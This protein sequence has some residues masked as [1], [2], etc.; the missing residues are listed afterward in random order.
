MATT[1]EC[2]D[3]QH[4]MWLLLMEEGVEEGVEEDVK[5]LVAF[6]VLLLDDPLLRQLMGNN[7]PKTIG[8]KATPPKVAAVLV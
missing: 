8:R 2:E 4:I 5:V 7:K 6:V 3:S 1:I